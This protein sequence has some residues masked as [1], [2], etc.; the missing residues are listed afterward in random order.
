M[1][2]VVCGGEGVEFGGYGCCFVGVGPAEG[3]LCLLEVGPGA[4]DAI[5]GL[6][7][8]AEAGQGVCLVPGAVDR[9]RYLQGCPVRRLG[10]IETAPEPVQGSC[11]VERFGLTSGVTDVAVDVQRRQER[12][13]RA[14]VVSAQPPYR[15]EIVQGVGLASPVAEVAADLQPLLVRSGGAFIPGLCRAFSSR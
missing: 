14:V 15:P 4:G 2:W 1:D 6:G 3:F 9:L 5:S 10:L 8:A 12:F 7:T 13:R 11:F